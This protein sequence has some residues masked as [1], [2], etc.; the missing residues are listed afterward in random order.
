MPVG[1]GGFQ[2]T[3]LVPPFGT[4]LGANPL[5][6]LPPFPSL[7]FLFRFTSSLLPSNLYPPPGLDWPLCHCAIAQASPLNKHW[8]P[9]SKNKRIPKLLSELP[10]YYYNRFTALW[11]LSRTTRVSQHQKGKTNLDLLEQ[12]RVTG[13]GISWAICK[14][15]P[16]PRYIT[17]PASQHTVFYR[18]DALPAA[19]PTASKH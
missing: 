13:N 9:L 4:P 1:G 2:R 12:E 14:S 17:T 16:H 11:I 18:P 8:R 7:L 6:I 15:A 19:Q 10:Y 3:L 5:T